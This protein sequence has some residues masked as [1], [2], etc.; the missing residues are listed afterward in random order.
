[1]AYYFFNI[2]LAIICVCMIVCC[3]GLVSCL[4]VDLVFVGL[5]SCFVLRLWFAVLVLCW[6]L[7][8][9]VCDCCWFGDWLLIECDSIVGFVRFVW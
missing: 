9:L 1:M 5:V 2:C 6:W 4:W 3:C 7:I 8:L